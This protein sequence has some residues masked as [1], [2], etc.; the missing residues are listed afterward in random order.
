[1]NMVS[2]RKEFQAQKLMALF[3]IKI[4]DSENQRFP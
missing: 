4:Q 1:M 3:F 2:I